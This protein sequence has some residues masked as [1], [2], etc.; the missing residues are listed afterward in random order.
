M[1][2][3]CALCTAG[4]P[5]AQLRSEMLYEQGL[6]KDLNKARV[7][8]LG[9]KILA[10][11]DDYDDV[12]DIYDRV[13]NLIDRLETPPRLY[14]CFWGVG[15]ERQNAESHTFDWFD[16]DKGYEMSNI[17]TIDMLDIGEVADLTDFSGTHLIK[18]IM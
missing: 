9:C 15:Y 6:I 16:V 17:C 8:L 1:N 10:S 7:E 12:A 18:R 13:V 14:E 5:T 11:G 3:I 4:M 2:K